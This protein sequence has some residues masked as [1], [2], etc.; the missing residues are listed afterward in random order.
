MTAPITLPSEQTGSRW[1]RTLSP[2]MPA[3][4]VRRWDAH[5]PMRDAL[6]T[7]V[8]VGSGEAKRIALEVLR[9]VDEAPS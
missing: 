6:I 4:M 1:A 9:I 5:D 3:E 2:D 7:I 8:N